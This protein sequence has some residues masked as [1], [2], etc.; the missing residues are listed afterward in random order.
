MSI[1]NHKITSYIFAFAVGIS[2][3]I[4]SFR[5]I[6]DP[7]PALERAREEAAVNASREILS[8]QIGN[9]NLAIVDPLAPDRVVGKTYIYPGENGWQVSGYY[10]RDGE[11]RWHPYLM[12]MDENLRLVQMS[13][14]DTDQTLQRRAASEPRLEIKQ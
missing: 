2:L 8:D 12:T 14:S 11:Q 13:V 7:Q 5:V 4:Y 10:R 3:S 9:P 1:I 6:T